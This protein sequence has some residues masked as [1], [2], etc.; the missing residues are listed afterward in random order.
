MKT[1]AMPQTTND[2]NSSAFVSWNAQAKSSCTIIDESALNHLTAHNPRA[3]KA[4]DMELANENAIDGQA[5]KRALMIEFGWGRMQCTHDAA[6]LPRPVPSL[7]PPLSPT[8]AITRTVTRVCT[9]CCRT[10][11]F[12]A[13]APICARVELWMRSLG[14]Q[15]HPEPLTPFPQ[16]F[17]DFC[18]GKQATLSQKHAA[19]RNGDDWGCRHPRGCHCQRRVRRRSNSSRE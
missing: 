12:C 19:A 15:P 14:V 9:I 13:R 3:V 8:Y 6:V 2:E 4:V 18:Q 11:L 7:S 10:A 5:N 1:C 16:V 17:S